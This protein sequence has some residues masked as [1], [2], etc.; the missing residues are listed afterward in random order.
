MAVILSKEFCGD[1][2]GLAW[3]DEEGKEEEEEEEEGMV[4]VE[5]GE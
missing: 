2:A 1:T 3:L 5:E 4:V